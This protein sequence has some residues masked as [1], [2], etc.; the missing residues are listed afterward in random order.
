MG[1]GAVRRPD[2]SRRGYGNQHGYAIEVRTSALEE[3][4]QGVGATTGASGLFKVG[5]GQDAAAVAASAAVEAVA[6]FNLNHPGVKA[7]FK[8]LEVAAKLA[9]VKHPAFSE[10]EE[11]RLLTVFHDYRGDGFG[12]HHIETMF[13]ATPMAVVPYVEFPLPLDAIVSVKVGPGDSTGVREIGVRRLLKALRCT[14]IVSRSDV[15]FRF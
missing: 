10:E 7:E 11:W 6:Q 1:D 2:Q 12:L 5:Y 9:T 4:L 3:V 13:R 8:A 15:P 14:A